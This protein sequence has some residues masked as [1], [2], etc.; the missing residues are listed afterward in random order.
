MQYLLELHKA[1]KW[2]KDFGLSIESW[3][4]F[5]ES[6][7]DFENSDSVIPPAFHFVVKWFVY[8]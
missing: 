3:N 1:S 5:Q 7:K 8:V 4:K 6:Q 2:V